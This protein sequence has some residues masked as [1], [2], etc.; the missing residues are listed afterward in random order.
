[1]ITKSSMLVTHN[2]NAYNYKFTT[3]ELRERYGKLQKFVSFNQ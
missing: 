2:P 3:W 1:M